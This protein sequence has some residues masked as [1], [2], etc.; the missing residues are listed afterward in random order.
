M[1][2]WATVEVIECSGDQVSM[3]VRSFLEG[4]KPHFV[5]NMV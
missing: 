3:N 2:S 4:G 5:V 1:M